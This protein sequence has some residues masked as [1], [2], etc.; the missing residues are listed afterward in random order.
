MLSLNIIKLII[1]TTQKANGIIITSSHN[2]PDYDGIKYNTI[3]GW[4]V[5]PAITH[6]IEQISNKFLMKN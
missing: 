6:D 2:P 3:S 1:T 5:S 4:L